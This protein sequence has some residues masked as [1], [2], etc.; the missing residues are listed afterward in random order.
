MFAVGVVFRSSCSLNCCSLNF[1]WMNWLFE[2][3]VGWE[4]IGLVLVALLILLTANTGVGTFC[5]SSQSVSLKSSVNR[6]A[7]MGIRFTRWS[8]ARLYASIS[9]W[10]LS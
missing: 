8:I 7:T 5:K 3:G 1:A 2:I 9:A 4:A 10:S 6:R